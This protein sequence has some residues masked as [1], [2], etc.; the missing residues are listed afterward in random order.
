MVCLPPWS[1]HPIWKRRESLETE[2]NGDGLV[3]FLNIAP[4]VDVLN[5]GV[6]QFEAD[7]N[8]DGDVNFLDIAPFVDFLNGI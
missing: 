7:I 6:Y 3:D 1:L 2:R 5:D 8:Q 4:F